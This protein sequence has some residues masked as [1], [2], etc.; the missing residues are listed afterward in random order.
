VAGALAWTLAPASL[1]AAVAIA[2]LRYRLYDIDRIMPS[3]PA[4]NDP[5]TVTSNPQQRQASVV[6]G[7]ASNATREVNNGDT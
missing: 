6:A 2:V 5:G 3:T 1:S 7:P 4:R